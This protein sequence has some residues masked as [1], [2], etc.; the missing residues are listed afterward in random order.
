MQAYFRT[1]SIIF[2]LLAACSG[3]DN[4]EPEVFTPTPISLE[5]PSFFEESILAPV[6]PANNPLTEE[7]VALGKK[8]FFDPILSANNTISCAS[9]HNPQASFTDDLQFS[10]GIDDALGS[11]NSMPLFNLA[12]HYD[13]RFFWDG[14]AT[15]LEDQAFEPVTN[16]NEMGSTWAN[17]VSAL[18]QSQEYPELFRRA[19]GTDG[20]DSVRVAMAIAQF[21]R[22]LISDNSRFDRSLRGEITLTEE[23]SRGV[24][25]FMMETKG[26][27]F[28][29]HGNPNNPLW[30]DNIFR[31]NGLDETF[32][33]LGL[34]AITGDPGDNGKFKTPSLRNLAYTAPYMH[35]GRFATLDEVINHYSEGLRNSPTIDPL[36]KKVIEGGVQLSD[37]D[38]ADLKAF[39]LSLSDPD[40]IQNPDF[41]N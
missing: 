19:F 35:D 13:E 15:S 16:P 7:G 22:T 6:I 24:A 23:E 31:N 29:C 14:S 9:C 4:E 12:W 34:G 10:R 37:Q 36:M 27:C 11:R 38:K 39:L 8:L 33:D 41:Q 30:T 32:E 28:H 1:Y 17:A 20:I 3:D 18:K 40:F 5:I 2:L 21:E 26:D 25:V